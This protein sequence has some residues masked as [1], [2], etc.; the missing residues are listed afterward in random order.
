ME[1]DKMPVPT[2]ASPAYHDA[3]YSQRKQ[4]FGQ[5]ILV[6]TE[7]YLHRTVLAKIDIRD[8]VLDRIGGGATCP[9]P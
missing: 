9:A 1:A 8:V 4:P 7:A 6:T 3:D 5:S 2:L